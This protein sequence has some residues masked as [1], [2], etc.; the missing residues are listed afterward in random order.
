M[1][2]RLDLVFY[3]VMTPIESLALLLGRKQ[4]LPHIH[5]PSTRAKITNSSKCGYNKL[6]TFATPFLI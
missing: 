3:D 1:F 5:I 6:N 4:T 2:I